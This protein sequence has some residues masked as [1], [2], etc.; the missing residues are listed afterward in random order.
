MLKHLEKFSF[1]K[2][3]VP[4]NKGLSGYKTSLKGTPSPLKGKKRIFTKEWLVNLKKSKEGGKFLSPEV[5]KRISEKISIYNRVN[6]KRPPIHRGESNT[7]WKGG[8]TPLNEKTRKSV[9][10]KKWRDLVF[11]RDD[12]TCQKCGKRGGDLEA[13]HDL[14][15]SLFPDLRFEVLNGQTLCKKCHRETPTYGD[16]RAIKRIHLMT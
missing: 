11:R 5:R 15:F 8:I 1:K 12:Y 7:N 3:S 10:Y 6:K 16:I 9:E 13:D 2:G 14:P 4:W